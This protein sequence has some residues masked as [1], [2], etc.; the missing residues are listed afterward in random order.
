MPE[1]GFGD[2]MVF[3]DVSNLNIS[4]WKYNIRVD[5]RELNR[6]FKEKFGAHIQYAYCSSEPDGGSSSFHDMLELSGYRLKK[7]KPRVDE[8]GKKHEKEVDTSLS[9]DMVSSVLKGLTNHVVL[10]TRD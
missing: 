8:M 6:Y 3:I 1:R 5:F 2:A 4:V 10:V 7:Y 9:V